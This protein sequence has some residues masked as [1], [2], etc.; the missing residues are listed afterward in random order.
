MKKQIILGAMAIMLSVGSVFAQGQGRTMQTPEQR[1][2]ATFEKMAP[3]NLSAEQNDK[4][5]AALTAFYTDQQKSRDEMRAS[6]TM[7][8]DAII[9]KNEELTKK[10]E[11][12]LKAIL[13]PEQYKKWETD[14]LP[15]T[16][17]Q[18]PAGN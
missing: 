18:R 5:K 1:T 9:A 16:R 13:T 14:I 3:L 6:G 2:T 17:P 4:V 10:R 7:D 8:R 11:E 12:A 15:T